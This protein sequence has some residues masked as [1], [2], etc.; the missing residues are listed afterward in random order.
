MYGSGARVPVVILGVIGG[1]GSI[2]EFYAHGTATTL[3]VVLGCVALAVLAWGIIG[4]VRKC[5]RLRGTKP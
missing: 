1:G 2:H 5:I 3:G 4:I